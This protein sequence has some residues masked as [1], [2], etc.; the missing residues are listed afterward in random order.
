LL[1][2]VVILTYECQHRVS[3]IPPPGGGG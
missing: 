1:L 3:E 2:D